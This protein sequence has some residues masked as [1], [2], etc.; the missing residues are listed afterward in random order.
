MSNHIKFAPNRPGQLK[1]NGRGGY[2]PMGHIWQKKYTRKSWNCDGLI[3]VCKRC[4]TY[5]WEDRA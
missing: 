2:R 3:E 5:R 4:G 1:C